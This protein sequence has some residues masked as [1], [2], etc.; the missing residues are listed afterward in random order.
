MI[1]GQA[2]EKIPVEVGESSLRN[3]D[4]LAPAAALCVICG[5]ITMIERR[6]GWDLWQSSSQNIMSQRPKLPKAKE[7]NASKTGEDRSYQILVK[8]REVNVDCDQH[9]TPKADLP[10]CRDFP[11]S[12]LP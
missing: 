10:I 9:R 8:W 5:E 2:V 11:P 6:D 1:G 3:V 12:R 4:Q 7:K